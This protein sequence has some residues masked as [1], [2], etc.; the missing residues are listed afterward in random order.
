[1]NEP[2]PSKL[3]LLHFARRVVIQQATAAVAQIDTWIAQEE[4][5]QAHRR[6]AEAMRPP[7][8]D[9]LLERGLNKTNTVAV[10]VGG[11]WTVRKSSRCIGVSQQQ[12]LDALRQQV[13]ACTHCRPDTELGYL[14]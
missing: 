6:Q 12:A 8:A 14:E 9:W 10:H 7:P 4:E 3:D 5:R 2:A 13:P 11:C 1:M